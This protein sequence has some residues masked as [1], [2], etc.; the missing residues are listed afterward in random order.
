[1]LKRKQIF[2]NS[3]FSLKALT[4]FFYYE[5]KLGLN[6]GKSFGQAGEGSMRLNV[7]MERDVLEEA[8]QRLLKAVKGLDA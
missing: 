2:R 5:A 4:H 1:M 8:M 6:D 3:D 7:G